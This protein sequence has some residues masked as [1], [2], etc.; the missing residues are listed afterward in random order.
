M[1]DASVA[2]IEPES[3]YPINSVRHIMGWTTESAWREARRRGLNERI[4]V[5]GKRSYLLGR[6]VIQFVMSEGK[7]R[8]QEMTAQS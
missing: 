5:V 3:M 2:V 8:P 6:D 1:K 4:K 7:S